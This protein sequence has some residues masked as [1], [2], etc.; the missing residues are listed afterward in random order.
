MLNANRET[1][2]VIT[3]LFALH[4]NAKVD[5]LKLK[6]LEGAIEYEWAQYTDNSVIAV[7]LI[8]LI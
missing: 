1:T 6:D 7:Y 5:H 4:A 3:N 8:T 2:M